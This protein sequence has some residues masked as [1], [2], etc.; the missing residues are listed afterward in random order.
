MCYDLESERFQSYTAYPE[1]SE[2]IS[3][4]EHSAQV[5]QDNEIKSEHFASCE[6]LSDSAQ[7]PLKTASFSECLEAGNENPTSPLG[8]KNISSSHSSDRSVLNEN[9]DINDNKCV[10]P[11]QNKLSSESSSDSTDAP[12]TVISMDFANEDLYPRHNSKTFCNIPDPYRIPT[13][14]PL[15]VDTSL[16]NLIFEQNIGSICPRNQY[17]SVPGY[18]VCR[19][20]YCDW[21]EPVLPKGNLAFNWK[22]PVDEYIEYHF[23]NNSPLCLTVDSV[24]NNSQSVSV[25]QISTQKIPCLISDSEVDKFQQNGRA[26]LTSSLHLDNPSDREEQLSSVIDLS[27]EEQRTDLLS[28][29]ISQVDKTFMAQNDNHDSYQN[30]NIQLVHQRDCQ[31]H[32]N[33]VP[34]FV[35]D[36][37]GI[38]GESLN[39]SQFTSYNMLCQSGPAT[40]QNLSEQANEPQLLYLVQQPLHSTHYYFSHSNSSFYLINP[41]TYQYWAQLS[42]QDGEPYQYA[43]VPFPQSL[44]N[45]CYHQSSE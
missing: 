2:R 11:C 27:S 28:P 30:E 18:S 32:L 23:R 4:T 40:Y 1:L 16:A 6:N 21:I 37:Q 42:D 44:A 24:R 43:Y 20:I 39:S 14:V 38:A 9:L 26:Q 29:Q 31:P 22:R 15:Y 13:S 35:Q 3:N 8:R 25:E 19:N 7:R 10:L 41:N 12:R 17:L 36:Q 34:E 45:Y 33:G 5:W